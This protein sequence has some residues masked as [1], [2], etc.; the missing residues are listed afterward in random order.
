[1]YPSLPQR[2]LVT[3]IQAKFAQLSAVQKWIKREVDVAA[4]SSRSHSQ[5]READP[6]EMEQISLHRDAG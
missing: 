1:M 4:H 2:K 5:R 6:E 3:S